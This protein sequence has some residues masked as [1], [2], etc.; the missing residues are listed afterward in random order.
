M[1]EETIHPY[2]PLKV[3]DFRLL[4]LSIFTIALAG[5]VQGVVVAWQIYAITTDP[6]ALGLLGLAEAL[7]FI[8]VA[9]FAGHVADTRNRQWIAVCSL[10]T[11]LACAIAL[12]VLSLVPEFQG[13]EWAIYGVIVLSG[14]ARSFLGPARTALSAE[15]VP[16]ELYSSSVT[17]RTTTWQIAMVSGPALGGGLYALGSERLAYAV[18]VILAFTALAFQLAVRPPAR[19]AATKHVSIWKS[20][21][22]GISFLL[23]QKVILSAITLDLFAVLFGGAV[24]L[25]PIYASEILKVGPAGLGLLRAAPAAGAVVMSVIL[26]H[27]GPF[28]R[29]GVA[30]LLN[31][32][33][34]GV[35]MILFGVSTSF[36][37]SLA[38]LACSGAVD[39]VSV[40]IR[41]TLVQVL[42]PEHMLGRISAVN[43]IFIGSSNE[44]GA[45]ESGLA[46]K[47]FG[48]VR[49]VVAGGVITLIV[50]AVTA[51]RVPELRALRRIGEAE[52]TK[53][54]RNPEPSHDHESPP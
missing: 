24:A 31:V 50:V 25:L 46:A 12:L 40:V 20:L 42:T 53:P 22:E 9:L 26:T 27:R 48:T 15:V 2:L 35:S 51:W 7:P 54:T 6:L 17:W 13:L 32:A 47:L 37:L 23:R 36:P 30:L 10:I 29:A 44:I 52:P 19:R 1:Q 11:L 21:E 18:T 43:A 34:F 5:Q 28:Q 38:L 14:V 4:L 45:F 39:Y 33:L 49:S 41:H 3:R 16:R 8:A